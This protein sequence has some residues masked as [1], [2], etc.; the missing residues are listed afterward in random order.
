MRYENDNANTIYAKGKVSKLIETDRMEIELNFETRDLSRS[1]SIENVM[2]QCEAFLA[3]AKE[4]GME[5]KQMELSDD[6][7]EINGYRDT[8][9]VRVSRTIKLDSKVDINLVNTIET[10]IQKNH[11]DVNLNINYYISN[12]E[13]YRK[14]LLKEAVMNSRLR[15]ESIADAAGKKI[16]G[17]KS[18]DADGRYSLAKSVTLGDCELEY[19][20][21]LLSGEL[22]VNRKMLEENIDTWWYME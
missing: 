14:E 11:W 18:V 3:F 6:R 2:N 8:K 9:E 22:S 16:A 4:L 10:Q 7:I 17:L 15:A 19:P 20:S 12:E 13:E 1:K 5:L 21:I